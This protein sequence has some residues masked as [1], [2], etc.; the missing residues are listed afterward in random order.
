MN[1]FRLITRID[2]RA[3][4]YET[5][6]PRLLEDAG[7]ERKEV[8]SIVSSMLATFTPRCFVETIRER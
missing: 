6:T 1:L 5:L 3:S 7:I 2:H 8:R 4:G